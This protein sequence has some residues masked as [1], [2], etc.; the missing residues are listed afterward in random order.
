VSQIVCVVN[1]LT[2]VLFEVFQGENS[3]KKN[4]WSYQS[5]E[6]PTKRAAPTASHFDELSGFLEGVDDESESLWPPPI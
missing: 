3:M 4:T 2:V 1:W 5:K 6:D